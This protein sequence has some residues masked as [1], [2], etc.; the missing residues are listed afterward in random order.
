MGKAHPYT[1]QLKFE[2]KPNAKMMSALRMKTQII[3]SGACQ[4]L[5][6]WNFADY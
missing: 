3:D 6:R 5:L 1:E 2:W 4:A